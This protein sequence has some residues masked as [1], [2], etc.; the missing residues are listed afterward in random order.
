MLMLGAHRI[1]RVHNLCRRLVA[2]HT[3]V[4][5]LVK[6]QCQKGAARRF[7]TMSGVDGVE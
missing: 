5:S 1:R 3:P 2:G 7:D 6:L 4:L